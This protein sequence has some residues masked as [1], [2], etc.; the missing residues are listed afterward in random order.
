MLKQDKVW[1]GLLTGVVFPLIFFVIFH[2]LNSVLTGRNMLSGDG[3][4]LKFICIVTVITNVI[5]A[6]QY[7]KSKR[8]NALKGIVTV[9]ML[10]G[11]GIVIYFHKELLS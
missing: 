4:S 10:Y 11:F 7:L 9:T 1:V 2:E 3:V 6:G 5:P 8:D